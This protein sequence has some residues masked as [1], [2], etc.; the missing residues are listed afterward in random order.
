MDFF[1]WAAVNSHPWK[2]TAAQGCSEL[3]WLSL[4]EAGEGRGPKRLSWARLAL[5]PLLRVPQFM[6]I[7]VRQNE[8]LSGVNAAS[9][10]LGQNQDPGFSSQV[11]Y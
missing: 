11:Y 7:P 10:L 8:A 6:K 5:R 4:R 2:F 9:Q 1:P 3:G